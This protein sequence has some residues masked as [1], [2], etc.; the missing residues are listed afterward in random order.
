MKKNKYN[1]GDKV[2]HITPESPTGIVVDIRYYFS[3]DDYEYHVAWSPS[4]YN[5][6]T[7]NELTVSKIY[8]Y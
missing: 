8:N 5:W 4:E 3:S 2:Y 7:G 6:Y 1:I